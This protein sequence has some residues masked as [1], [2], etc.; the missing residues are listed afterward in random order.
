MSSP[1]EGEVLVDLFAVTLGGSKELHASLVDCVLSVTS[2]AG[3]WRDAGASPEECASLAQ[4]LGQALGM[5]KQM[6]IALLSDAALKAFQEHTEQLQMNGVL[7]AKVA[8]K[9][10]KGIKEDQNC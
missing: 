6:V 1:K 10:F 4:P 3:K 9:A 8:A 2:A 5:L 7:Y